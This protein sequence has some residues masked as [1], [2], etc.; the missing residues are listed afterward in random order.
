MST[1][2]Y[3]KLF[4]HNI[5]FKTSYDDIYNAFDRIGKLKYCDV[6]V[7]KN[8]RLKGYAFIEYFDSHLAEVALKDLNGAHIGLR[9]IKIEY[10][11]KLK[12]GSTVGQ[13]GRNDDRRQDNRHEGGRYD[14]NRYDDR[15]HD[16][17]RHDDRRYDGGSPRKF[18][19]RDSY[20]QSR[21]SR[22][23]ERS[24]ESKRRSSP[25]QERRS[26]PT[27]TS[28][29]IRKGYNISFYE[30]G[31][32]YDETPA[33]GDMENFLKKTI[34]DTP[35]VMDTSRRSDKY[36]SRRMNKREY[37]RDRS[38]RDYRDRREYSDH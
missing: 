33:P 20:R 27:I 2:N 21:R 34:K 37:S 31:E 13:G 1:F 29:S 3:K 8:K 35:T 14:N 11:N 26:H 22:D 28:D 16:D 15:R 30:A 23:Y 17:R 9:E 24:E 38:R 6:P 36:D 12:E 4:V 5:D 32:F 19:Q 18:H 7:D 10:S 25:S